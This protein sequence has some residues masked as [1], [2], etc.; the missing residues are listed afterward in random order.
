MI[1]APSTHALSRRRR[2]RSAAAK[3]ILRVTGCFPLVA[4]FTS[5]RRT[6]VNSLAADAVNKRTRS[7][8]TFSSLFLSSSSIADRVD[9]HAHLGSCH[10]LRQVVHASWR[11]R[12]GCPCGTPFPCRRPRCV[13]SSADRG[14]DALEEEAAPAGREGDFFP[15]RMA[16][17]TKGS[18]WLSF[19]ADNNRDTSPSDVR[20]AISATSTASGPVKKLAARTASRRTRGAGRRPVYEQFQRIGIRSRQ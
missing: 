8:M 18:I 13:S 3:P 9:Q 5:S 17:V 20:P 19:P 11:T 10:R 2:R 7:K 1:W 15:L 4:I 16:L 12:R 14:V 6:S